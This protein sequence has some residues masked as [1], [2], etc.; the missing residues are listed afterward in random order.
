MHK[1]FN[2]IVYQTARHHCLLLL[3]ATTTDIDL[4]SEGQGQWKAK[5]LGFMSSFTSTD[6]DEI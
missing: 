1:L 4:G 3:H 2:Q 6:Q 5:Y